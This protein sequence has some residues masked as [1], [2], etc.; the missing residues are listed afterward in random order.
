MVWLYP[1]LALLSCALISEETSFRIGAAL[2][3]TTIEGLY[4]VPRYLKPESTFY[5]R[6]P[7]TR[8]LR[9]SS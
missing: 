9:F 4:L 6:E 3:L 7:P 2:A 5:F 8:E 1:M